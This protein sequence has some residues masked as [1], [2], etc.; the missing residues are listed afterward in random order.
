M[1]GKKDGD[2]CPFS[3]P[4]PCKKLIENGINGSKGCNKGQSC[5]FFH[6]RI[7]H[8]SLRDKVCT[9][10][11]C[12][13]VHIKGTRRNAIPTIPIAYNSEYTG[14]QIN[15]PTE[16]MRTSVPQ[17]MTLPCQPIRRQPTFIATPEQPPNQSASFLEALNKM[18]QE[19]MKE[20]ELK[21]QQFHP[22]QH[23]VPYMTYPNQHKPMYH[24]LYPQPMHPSPPQSGPL[25]H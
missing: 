25:V 18:K 24:H 1:S 21:L 2:T 9:D 20:M 7:C 22:S 3:H 10:N 6:P 4:K 15:R 14:I 13:F 16:P 8:K 23:H 12:K 11:A 5:E 17:L 19:I